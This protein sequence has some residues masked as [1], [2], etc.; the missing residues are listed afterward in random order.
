MEQRPM[1]QDAMEYLV[2]KGE[3]LATAKYEASNNANIIDLDSQKYLYRRGELIRIKPYQ[4]AYPCTF[5][6]FTLNGL[7]D[8]I[9]ADTDKLFVAEKPTA[10]VRVTS[11]TSVQVLG[12]L[13]G[14]ANERP[15]LAR[16]VYHA[17]NFSFDRYC[18]S[19]TLAVTIQT[20]FH[21][22]E[23]RDVVL[24]VISNMTEEQSLQTADD[25]VSQRV[26]LKH[27]VQEIDK[28][29]FVNPAYLHP[30]RTFTEIEQPMSPFV[31]RFKEGKQV[32]LFEA[33]GGK[34][35]MEAVKAIGEYLKEQ[36]E[37][38]NVVVI[39]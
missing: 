4:Q 16:C 31:V 6:S 17:P 39:A 22:D 23:C 5:E 1:E 26:T 32:A 13:Q 27:G 7:I 24:K 15:L 30:M 8:W 12:H 9:K 20:C 33:D 28:T 18:D 38:Q 34:W 25:G 14:D 3:E 36:L 10:I 29:V 35:Q 2:N 21:K 19:E 11:P 37:G